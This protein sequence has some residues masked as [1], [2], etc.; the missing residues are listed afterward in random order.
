MTDSL[1]LIT[2][3]LEIVGSGIVATFFLPHRHIPRALAAVSALA[4]VVIMW[5][6]GAALFAGHTFHVWLW[7]IPGLGRL[8][9]AIDRIGALFIFI[10]GLIYL[11]VSIFSAGY[12]PRFGGR[13]SLKS[14]SGW[15][16]VLFASIVFIPL[17]GDVISFFLLWEVMSITSYLLVVYEHEKESNVR[18]GWS[19][20]VMS[21]AGTLAALIAF[22]I[23]AGHSG[24]LD[25]AGIR[26]GIAGLGA[27][28]RWAVFLLTFFGFGVKTG[29]FPLNLW[30]P[31]AHPVAPGNVS[32]L[33][34]GV[35]LNLG[36][37]GI[38]RVNLD[39]LPAVG[40][41]PGLVVLS[42]GAVTALIGILYATIEDD[43][44]TM[45][46]HSSI[47]NMG[48]VTV[49]LGAGMTFLAAG[50]P[51]LA[52]IAFV[53][54]F[55]HMVNHSAY[56]GL[57]FL[58]ASTVD[59]MTGTRSMDRL[60]GLIHRLPW[61][62]VAF[63]V[64]AMSISALPPFNGFVSEWLILQSILRS[65]ELS[66]IGVKVIF[67]LAGA[68]LALTAALAVT[69]FVKAFAM[70]FL[71]HA[72]SESAAS[73]NRTTKTLIVP[74]LILASLCL[75]LGVTPTYVVPTID[76][77]IGEYTHASATSA[78]VPPFFLATKADEHGLPSAF[79]ADFHNLGAQAGRRFLP[80]RGLV[81]LHRGGKT[82]PVVYAMSPAYTFIV[83]LIMLV[84]TAGGVW[85]LAARKRRVVRGAEWA[86]GVRRLT[87]DMTYTATGF[88]KP[89]RV[90][91]QAIFH[92]T[93]VEE[94][95]EAASG[96]FRIAI[97]RVDQDVYLPERFVFHPLTRLSQWIAAGCAR[98]HNGK[99]N[100]YA[101]YVFT[102]LILV[103]TIGI[104]IQQ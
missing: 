55:Y 46:A 31:R 94:R 5:G 4:A 90:I 25:F 40:V 74:M 77:A 103:I 64:G 17:C 11:P 28:A 61:T 96:H 27:G 52:A 43:L 85:L 63:L 65:V 91:F 62:A 102:A 59:M 50:H 76:R 58:G 92:P 49:G 51:T 29:L 81:I 12:L 41:G 18:A 67:A 88:A 98:M 70:T 15:Y 44:K 10:T 56:K 6:S 82:N 93:V 78:L 13:Y 69:A 97:R 95:E 101:G 19:M 68:I 48:I 80:G 83:L 21:E 45:L 20:L 30:L 26:A 87:P 38:V 73:A 22:L 24:V 8:S 14:F 57:L 37:Y 89:V 39:L 3:F 100:T 1:F 72:R 9:L 66:S 32:A 23:L 104:I 71:G 79:V 54:A 99:L 53:A 34:S 36:I 60:G 86:G 7:T 75:T 47:E 16:L 2:V 35:I 42:V 84:L 33:L